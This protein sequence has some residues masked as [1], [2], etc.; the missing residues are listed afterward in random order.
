[1]YVT[2]IAN[3]IQLTLVTKATTG[4]ITC[5]EVADV[6]AINGK[7]PLTVKSIL[8]L[9]AAWTKSCNGGEVGACMK[10]L[11]GELQQY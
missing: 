7:K 3:K 6:D 4:T 5:T 10:W 8:D 11:L 1:M 2:A 9:Y